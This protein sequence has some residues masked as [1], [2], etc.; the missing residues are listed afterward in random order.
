MST[1]TLLLAIFTIPLACTRI[2]GWSWD[3]AENAMPSLRDDLDREIAAY[4][5]QVLNGLGLHD[6]IIHLD[7]LVDNY[8][9]MGLNVA[10]L[11]TERSRLILEEKQQQLRVSQAQNQATQLYD[12]GV[13]EYK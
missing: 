4:R 1:L 5:Q 6:R 9:P 11:E 2:Y 10:E 7:R 13:T 3:S 12:R 8:K